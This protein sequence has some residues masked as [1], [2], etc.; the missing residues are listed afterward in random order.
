VE[1]EICEE[2]MSNKNQKARHKDTLVCGTIT[3]HTLSIKCTSWYNTHVTH[4]LLHVS[5]SWCRKHAV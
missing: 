2:S 4:K 1:R 5:K 3:A